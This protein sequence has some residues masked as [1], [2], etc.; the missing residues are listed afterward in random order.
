[1]ESE[2]NKGTTFYLSFPVDAE[3]WGM[4]EFSALSEQTESKE[5]FGFVPAV[6]AVVDVTEDGG[7]HGLNH[8]RRS[9]AWELHSC[10]G[11]MHHVDQCK[12]SPTSP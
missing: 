9:H 12:V 1:M 10:D 3:T 8:G 6:N 4:N 7:R 2:V 11:L 5:T